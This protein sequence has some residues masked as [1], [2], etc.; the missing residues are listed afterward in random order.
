MKTSVAAPVALLMGS[1]GIPTMGTV[2]SGP[3]LSNVLYYKLYA[4]T[5][6]AETVGM[7]AIIAFCK[8]MGW[9]RV[10]VLHVADAFGSS[11]AEVR[12]PGANPPLPAIRLLHSSRYSIELE[13]GGHYLSHCL[14][15]VSDRPAARLLEATLLTG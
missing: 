9:T 12:P 6:P 8:K 3:E 2:S 4:R 11:Y 14:G 10:A 1:Q 13:T 15:Y 7:T 5:S